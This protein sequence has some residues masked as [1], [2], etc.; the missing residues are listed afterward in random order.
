[1]EFKK[2]ALSVV[3][4]ATLVLSSFA[5]TYAP[6]A[7]AAL[8]ATKNP[9]KTQV[10]SALL[11]LSA[12]DQES[13]ELVVVSDGKEDIT[14]QLE[15]L[16]AKVLYNENKYVY[17]AEVPTAKVMDVY[18]LDNVAALSENY[19]HE[20]VENDDSDFQQEIDNV[21][22]KVSPS[23]V[24]THKQT[25]ADKFQQ[26]YDG[27]GTRVSIIDT[28]IDPGHTAFQQT[29]EGTEKI[30]GVEDY[31]LQNEL[32]GDYV[33]DGDVIFNEQ[34]DEGATI[35]TKDSG[36]YNTTGID[37]SDDKLWF[38]E[39]KYN[40]D[41]EEPNDLNADGTKNNNQDETFGVLV[42]GDDIYVDNNMD[43]DFTDEEAIS[44]TATS[45]LDVDTS[46]DV[47]GANYRV[48]GF[49][50]V[51][52]P[53]G[54]NMD[55]YYYA[56]FFA[57]TGGHGTHV[58]GITAANSPDG[59]GDDIYNVDM[60]GVSPGAE[61]VGH[62]VFRAG[63]GA[64][65]LSIMNAMVDA[66]LPEGEG[67][68]G[69]DVA[70]LSLGS[71]PDLNDGMNSYTELVDI[72]SEEYG[73]TY[74]MSAGNSGPGLDTVGSPGTIENA[75]SVGAYIDSEMWATE[76][77]AFPYGKNE[78]GSP[79][80][81]EGLWYFSSNGPRE[82]GLQ[83]PDIVAP[84]AAYSTVPVQEGAY[85]V[86]QGTSMSSPYVAGTVSILKNAAQEERVPFSY[87]SVREALIQTARSMDDYNRAEQ[88]AGLINVQDAFDYMEDNM[89][90]EMNNIDVSVNFGEKVAGGKG[91]S[92]RNTELPEEITIQLHNDS[93]ETKNL[94]LSKD[95]DW[96]KV[97]DSSIKLAPNEAK[98]ITVMYDHSKLEMGTNAGMITVDD[99]STA[100]AEAR[101]PQ[102]VVK[103][104]EFNDDNNYRWSME[105]EVQA[106]KEKSY[107]FDVERGVEEINVDLSALKE[108]GEYQ[109]RVRMI[110]FD[111]DGN[112]VSE[113][114]GYA[115][116][117][118]GGMEVETNTF[119][120]P[121][122]GTWEVAVY[123]SFGSEQETNKYALDVK[124]QG[125]IN[126][127]GILDLGISTGEAQSFSKEV[128]FTNYLSDDKEV[129]VEGG[130]FSEPIVEKERITAPNQ[131]LY[132]KPLEIKNN[133]SLEIRTNN[134][135]AASDDADLY[136]FKETEQG[137]KQIAIS[138]SATSDESLSFKG[139]E[140][141]NY[142]IGVLGYSGEIKLDLMTKEVKVLSPGEEGKGSITLP[143][144][145]YDMPVSGKVKAT[146]DI[147]TPE[148]NN[149]YYAGIFLRDAKTDEVLNMLPV[150][151]QE[152]AVT[153]LAGTNRVET[154]IEI[155]KDM[156]PTGYEA[157]AK[158]KAV[159]IATG[160]NFPDALSAGP[161][162]SHY[163]APILLTESGKALSQ[164]VLDELK[165]LHAEQAYIIGG[166]GVVPEK[167]VEQLKD[168][169]MSDAEIQR[170][171][172]DDRYETN[173]AVV[174]HLVDNGF[175]GNGV[176]MATGEKFADAL[177][178]GPF[179]GENKMP[180][181][182]TR[183]DKLPEGAAQYVKGE[184][185]SIVGGPGVVS[186][187]VMKEV[188]KQSSAV[189]RFAGTNR[190]E[191][192]KAVLE[193]YAN[194]T[195]TF[196]VSTGQKYPDALSSAPLVAQKGGVLLLTDTDEIPASVNNFLTKY[197]YQNNVEK[198]VAL[199]GPN[200]VSPEVKE[201]LLKQLSNE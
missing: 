166:D 148:E 146:A 96:F 18:K 38:G 5:G 35:D 170:F 53:D 160:N 29:T 172:G 126:N 2:K 22:D 62:K 143:D 97:S 45:T 191:T 87:K 83:K 189:K 1:M 9:I 64:A 6:K 14:K 140:D 24:E 73:I 55:D 112:E 25:G 19:T 178:A 174:S 49:E 155:S 144:K 105:D 199:G 163:Q 71:L 44:K 27:T 36:T 79:K 136:L 173:Q 186:K 135:E 141:G 76:Y 120:S 41:P 193:E 63:E 78:D 154:S 128:S 177:S 107:F 7:E 42:A 115:G 149:Q 165:R 31:T 145:T 91:V 3:T 130:A 52:A 66:A 65:T 33:A 116:S 85:G 153:T 40:A 59:T 106:S 93:D 102:T 103:A 118:N 192:L 69:S 201:A 109:G 142:A 99:E 60:K 104:N 89:I 198:I 124:A 57:D 74:V 108:N 157:A 72:L 4:G 95:A 183:E 47:A 150:Y 15:K 32:E 171:S 77:G 167:V 168:F 20:P 82:D 162:A 121:K 75:I 34:F 110:V 92:V 13:Q 156:Y 134:P 131:D 196:Y 127:P 138:G 21:N 81:G 117:G 176:F 43:K 194:P 88:G 94:K 114:Q 159:V 119:V 68:Y 101:I 26:K 133:V 90:K 46:D 56:N 158:N 86:K 129:Y 39:L 67:G 151:I 137:Y 70:N 10:S 125:V 111:P 12:S 181:L 179:A 182:L 98:T 51:E 58:A 200:A 11:A 132:L 123:A 195:D 190:Y 185:V 54:T 8:D 139:L 113:F 122:P 16:G 169:G 50:K 80:E 175:V 17:L 184:A 48:N 188:E 84:G 37:S 161:L 28:G 147:T 197:L 23:N 61:L 100:Y 180:I 30:V 164:D 187:D 152:N